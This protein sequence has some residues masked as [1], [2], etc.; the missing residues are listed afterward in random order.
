MTTKIKSDILKIGWYQ[1]VGGCFGAL[2]ILYSLYSPKQVSGYEVLVYIFILLFFGYSIFCG[3]LCI[4][5]K[6]NA[7][8]YSVINQ[9]LQLIG[10]SILGL[11]FTYVAGF[12]ISIG[13]EFSTTVKAKF[14]CGLSAFNLKLN[15]GYDIIEIHFNLIAFGLIYWILNLSTKIEAGNRIQQTLDKEINSNENCK[16]PDA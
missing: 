12:Y 14:E 13:L 1:I 3:T 16:I 9:F 8:T 5:H 7:L 2:V 11:A 6:D 4:K 15:R 10:F